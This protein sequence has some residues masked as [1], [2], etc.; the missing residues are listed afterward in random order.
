[1]AIGSAMMLGIEIPRNFDAPY[2]SKS[3]I[4]FWQ[5]WH[6]SL[7]NFITSYLFTPIVRSFKTKSLLNSTLAIFIAMSI[8]GLWHGA[9]LTFVVFGSLHGAYLGIN[10]YWRKKKMPILP[11]PLSWLLTFILV[12]IAFVYFGAQTVG[13]GTERVIA[14]FNPINALGYRNLGMMSVEGVSLH[15]YGL[16]LVLGGFAA[17]LGPSSEQLA[18]DFRPS[19]LN[20]ACAVV[21]TV[22]AFVF[23][24]SSIP[25]PFVYFR[26]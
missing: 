20:C 15:I 7:T 2:K 8:A 10:Q 17:F 23:I 22:V 18:R 24:N 9:A 3:I 5:R 16:P 11:A 14:L 12:V 25:K 13:Q 1:M 21:L 6:I 26:F 4:E 19:A